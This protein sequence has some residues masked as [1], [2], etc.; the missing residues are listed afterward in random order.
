M[1]K[2]V[3]LK[4]S[5]AVVLAMAMALPFVAGCGS[6][7]Y[8]LQEGKLQMGSDTSYPPFESMEGKTPVGFDVE[9]LGEIAKKMGLELE[10]ISTAWD[11][12][13]PGLKTKKY[14]VIM[15]AMTITPEREKEIAFSDPY[16]DSN[17]SIAVVKGSPIKTTADLKDK[18]VGVQ[19]DTT[20]QFEAEKIE[21]AGGLKEIQKFDTILVAFEALEQGKVDAI[22]NDLPVNSYISQ[23]RG[24]TEVVETIKTDEQYGIGI[25]QDN[26]EL[27]EKINTALQQV[28]DDGT[29]ARIYKQWFGTEPPK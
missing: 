9:L 5:L 22:I 28:K 23:K 14:D 27:L 18:V 6:S 24:K 29:Y 4:A 2:N 10:V 11:G 1:R 12:I 25:R 15:S 19:I 17:Q 13:I 7:G 16:I 8:L 21:K 20:G 26:T 3:W